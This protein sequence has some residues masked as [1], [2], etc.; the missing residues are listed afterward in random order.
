MMVTEE[1]RIFLFIRTGL[2]NVQLL[3]KYLYINKKKNNFLQINTVHLEL[4][5]YR[6]SR[7]A[8]LRGV[9]GRFTGSSHIT[10]FTA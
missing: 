1:G 10:E 5:T 9:H 3:L 7:K 2:L 4:R 6:K 8:S